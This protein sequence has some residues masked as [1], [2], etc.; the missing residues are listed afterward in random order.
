M[1]KILSLL[2][3]GIATIF[4]ISCSKQNTLDGKYYNQYDY[5][6]LEIKGNQGTYHENHNH[7]ITNVDSQ[8]KTFSFSASGREYVATYDIKKDG[9]L[10]F[11]I[12][13]FL[14]GGNKQTVYKKDSE[15]YKKNIKK[16]LRDF[17]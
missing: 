4:L 7:P 13:N 11:D 12:G 14:T 1:K 10:T 8:N 2:L 6:V 15:A 3:L 17:L 9:T 16:W 5:L